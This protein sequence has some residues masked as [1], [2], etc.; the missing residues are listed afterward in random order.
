MSGGDPA[1]W[2]FHVHLDHCDHCQRFPMD[3]CP[4]GAA[5]LERTAASLAVDPDAIARIG[6]P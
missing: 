2:E 3:L 5:A 4:D 6:R 1:T